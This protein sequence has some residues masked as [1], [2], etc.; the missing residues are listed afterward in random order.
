MKLTLLGDNF[1]NHCTFVV[2]V[3]PRLSDLAGGHAYISVIRECE[4]R[5][6]KIIGV[7][8]NREVMQT[9]VSCMHH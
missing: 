4:M 7:I 3:E 1:F 6:T 5:D 2:I 8:N 9:A